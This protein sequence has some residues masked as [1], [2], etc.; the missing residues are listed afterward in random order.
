MKLGGA[1]K[2]VTV[3]GEESPTAEERQLFEQIPRRHT[4]RFR[5]EPTDVPIEVQ[6]RLERAA[7]SGRGFDRVVKV[8]RTI[9][10]IE[11]AGCL[12]FPSFPSERT[13]GLTRLHLWKFVWKT[14][15]RLSHPVLLRLS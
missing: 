12:G 11:G 9:A 10:D 15:T 7:L 4:N 6:A 13:L 5:F 1:N 3:V 8:A 2:N 14:S